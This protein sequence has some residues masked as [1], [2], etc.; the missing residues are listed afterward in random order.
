MRDAE[1]YAK[2]ARKDALIISYIVRNEIESA[3]GHRLKLQFDEIGGISGAL[4]PKA[5]D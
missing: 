2:S 5:L 3:T 1:F 4:V